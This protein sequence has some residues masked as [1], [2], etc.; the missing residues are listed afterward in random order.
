MEVVINNNMIRLNQSQ[1]LGAGGEGTVFRAKVGTDVLAVKVY[2]QPDSIREAKLRAFLA[3]GWQLPTSRVALPLDLVFDA[4]GRNVIGLTMPFLGKGFEEL[5]SLSNRKYRAAYLV[6]SKNVADIFLDGGATLTQAHQNGLVIGDFNDLNGLFRGIEML[7][8]DVDAWQFDQFACPVATESF[9]A[10]E[11]YNIDLSLRPVFKPEY[12]WYSFAVMLFKSLLLVHPFGG[13]HKGLRQLT[14]RAAQRIT[15][16]D[17][18]VTYPRIALSPD[19]LNDDLAEAFHKVFALGKRKAFPLDTLR[20]YAAEL[21]EC[22]SCHT[23]YPQSRQICPVCNQ[24]TLIVIQQPIGVSKGVTA[25]EFLRVDGNIIY[26]KLEGTRLTVVAYEHGKAMLYRKIGT[27][28]RKMELFNEIP[29]AKYEILGDTL[30][31]NVPGQNELLLVDV[32]GDSI[33]PITKGETEIFAVNRR[34]MFRSSNQYLFHIINGNLMYAEVENGQLLERLLR[35]VMNQ[36]TWFAVRDETMSKPTACGFFQVLNQQMFWLVW[37]GAIYDDLPL[38]ELEA[39]ESLLDVLVRFSS[40]GALIRRLTQLAGVNY[41][42]TEMVDTNGK[43]VVS[44]ARVKQEDHP[45]GELHGQAYSTGKLLH[46]TDE[47]ILS[48]DVNTGGVKKFETTSQYVSQG[49]SLLSYQGG[50]L[51]VKDASVIQLTLS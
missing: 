10:P 36:Q 27:S 11:L 31:V 25:A 7:L 45:A 50:L 21:T 8:I 4:R 32:S 43:V 51:V 26:Y 33:K 35:P 3:K 39:S 20:A 23:F 13:T 38:A 18:G 12:D 24:K 48:E 22:P 15:V 46:A 9:L 30:I 5:A 44:S 6:N 41:L 29:G 42:R 40:Q 16:F 19:V 37:E 47:G 28:L 17:P 1:V 49:D 2:H 14:A 34:A